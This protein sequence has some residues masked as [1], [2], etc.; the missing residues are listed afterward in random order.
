MYTKS[1]LELII[2]SVLTDEVLP[3]L[4]SGTNNE[5][6]TDKLASLVATKLHEHHF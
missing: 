6:F 1:N 2:K 4:L 3:T 5:S